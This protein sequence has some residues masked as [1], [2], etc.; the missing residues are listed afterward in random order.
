MSYR[1]IFTAQSNYS[2]TANAKLTFSF[3]S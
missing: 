3:Y 2:L 1:L